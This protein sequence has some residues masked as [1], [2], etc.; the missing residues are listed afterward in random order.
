MNRVRHQDY[1][2]EW[3][4]PGCEL[5][6]HGCNDS[7]LNFGGDFIVW[8]QKRVKVGSGG[9]Q[10]CAGDMVWKECRRHQGGFRPIMSLMIDW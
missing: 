8:W 4:Q 1:K 6:I 10:N 2:Q 9:I 3:C 5:Y 7:R